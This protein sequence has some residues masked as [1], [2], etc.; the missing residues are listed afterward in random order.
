VSR[1]GV[2]WF[3]LV[4]L[5]GATNFLVKQRVQSLDDEL[6]HARRQT[7]EEQKKIHDLTAEWTFLNQPELLADLNNRYLHLV[8]VSPKQV[9][10]NIDSLPMRPAAPPQATPPQATTPLAA[11]Q[12]AAASEAAPAADPAGVPLDPP[13]AAPNPVANPPAAPVRAPIVT[14]S[15]PA[16]TPSPTMT[17]AAAPPARSPGPPPARLATLD[18]LFA[19]VA[20]NR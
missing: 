20:G 8:P 2:F 19:Q 4:I 13:S 7:V 5:S 15:A 12:V 14:V 11:P 3:I 18:A 6:N 17:A 16:P 9:Q 1:F 10:T